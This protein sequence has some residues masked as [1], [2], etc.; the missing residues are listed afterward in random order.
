MAQAIDWLQRRQGS[1]VDFRLPG[2]GPDIPSAVFAARIREYYA[3]LRAL[4][5]Q[6]GA[7]P[8]RQDALF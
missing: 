3:Q 2:D 5:R 6:P 7:P 1:I 8:A 4:P